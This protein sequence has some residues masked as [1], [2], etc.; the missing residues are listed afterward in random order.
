[1][2]RIVLCLA[3][4]LLIL[5]GCVPKKME[6]SQDEYRVGMWFSYNEV[7]RILNSSDYEG[8]FGTALENC[9][10]LGASDIFLH[11]RPYCDAIYPSKL[12]PLR[13]SAEGKGDIL[14]S[15]ID[16]THKMGMR[17][18]A[19]INPYRVR[20]ADEDISKLDPDSPAVK[21]LTD[22]DESNDKNVMLC[23][24]VYLDPSSEQVSRLVLDGIRELLDGYDIDGIHFDDYFYPSGAVPDSEAYESYCNGVNKPLSLEEWRRAHVN[25]LIS[26]VYTTVKH[27]GKEKLFSVSP[28]ASLENNRERLYADVEGW[29]KKGIL[30]IV[31][32]QLYFGFD[33]P[34]PEFRFEQLLKRWSDVPRKSGVEL[35]IGL[36]AYKLNETAAA[37]F[38]EWSENAELLLQQ[39]ELCRM[40]AGVSGQVYYSYTAVFSDEKINKQA[41]EALLGKE[42]YN[43][44]KN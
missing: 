22:A 17:F 11:V 14:A 30:D 34:L 3:L 8:A 15:F 12:F 20:S 10:R 43:V 42:N 1:M 32:P 19:W 36:G 6:T 4:V 41:L 44:K 33:Y 5:S 31:I 26:G 23:G 28:A 16:L 7:D 29:M 27:Y 2:K 35:W 39:S 25:A 18:H 38:K 37:D 24:G 9:A 13:K 40:Q 21:W